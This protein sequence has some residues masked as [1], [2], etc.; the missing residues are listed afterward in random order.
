[1]IVHLLGSGGFMPTGERET[2]CALL[3]DGSEALVIDAGT[4]IRRLVTDPALLDG[5]ERLHVLLTHF[6]LDHVIGLFYL[7]ELARPIEIWGAGER[8]EG[9]ATDE[10]V[11]RLLAPPFAPPS[12]RDAVA[13]ARELPADGRLGSFD[14]ASR[15]QR[16]HSNPTLAVRVGG[17]V[18]CTD[19]GY[20]AG[21]V[22]FARDAS[23]L[24]HDAFRAG[25]TGAEGGHTRAAN[26][27][28]LAAAAGV[29]RLVLIHLSPDADEEALLSEA[30]SQFEA[31]VVGRDG[32]S[33]EVTPRGR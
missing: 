30:R 14:V 33:L 13:R 23:V 16:I 24:F 5:V 21:N 3:R 28:R 31:T 1:V 20:D 26:A 7:A 12:I 19:T 9:I 17:M 10:L 25:E 11:Q 27:G 4:G 8:L 32:L 18:W 22:E 29:G 2:C 6:H 15:V